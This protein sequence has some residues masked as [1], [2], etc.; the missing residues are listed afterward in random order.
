[1]VPEADSTPTTPVFKAKTLEDTR[2]RARQSR[3]L[4]ALFEPGAIAVIGAS[5]REGSVGH[6]V[7]R[8]LLMNGYTGTLYPVN[9]KQPSI[10]GVKCHQSVLEIAEPVDMAVVAIP[11]AGVGGV[12][13]ECAR[14]G[15]HSAIVLSASRRWAARAPSWRRP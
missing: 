6:S 3:A 15:I 2:Q 4:K 5:R 1:M 7:F 11:A 10:M 14:K 9:P 8:N 12:L 13:G